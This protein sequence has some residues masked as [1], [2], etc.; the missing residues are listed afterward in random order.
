MRSA[1]VFAQKLDQHAQAISALSK[2]SLTGAAI[3]GQHETSGGLCV[4]S[5]ALVIMN[6]RAANEAQV[7]C[8]C[9]GRSHL[10]P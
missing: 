9:S 3:G 7:L 5:C 2:I 8:C 6:I 1:Q 10:Y 4:G